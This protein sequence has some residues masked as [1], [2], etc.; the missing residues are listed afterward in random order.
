MAYLAGETALDFIERFGV[1]AFAA[2][3]A[4][5][6]LDLDEAERRFA[7]VEPFELR[8]VDNSRQKDNPIH[9]GRRGFA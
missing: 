5:I 1:A 6:R 4:A 7:A 9:T 8:R 2:T 3:E